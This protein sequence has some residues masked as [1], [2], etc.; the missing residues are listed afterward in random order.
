MHEEFEGNELL[1][2]KE[3]FS[4]VHAEGTLPLLPWSY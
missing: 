3:N 2:R 1:R 4:Q